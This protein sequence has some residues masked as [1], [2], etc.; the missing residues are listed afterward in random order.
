MKTIL[1][2]PQF[3]K[4]N[5]AINDYIQAFIDRG[6]KILEQYCK[7]PSK[8]VWNVESINSTIRQIEYYKDTKVFSSKDDIVTIYNCLEKTI[9][10][11]ERQ[12]ELGY[13]FKMGEE[14]KGEKAA[15]QIYINEFILGDN[16]VLVLADD[17]KFAYINHSVLNYVM[18]ADKG[19]CDYTH[20]YIQNLLR[21][22]TL[23]SEVGEK[24][25]SRFFNMVREKI[26][27]RKAALLH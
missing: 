13:K 24:E 14:N 2:A 16:T 8:E 26:S 6:A 1:Q 23:I 25:R 19:F 4:I 9:D 11:I 27:N 18:T 15:Y 3:S 10:H 17:L 21:K 5:F 12:A 20:Q 22:S 7:L